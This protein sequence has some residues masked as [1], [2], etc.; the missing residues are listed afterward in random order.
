[1]A[2]KKT[3]W[4]YNR[5]GCEWN[6]WW[7]HHGGRRQDTV[8]LVAGLILHCH[9]SLEPTDLRP[10]SSITRR[11]RFIIDSLR[12]QHSR[13]YLPLL[14]RATHVCSLDDSTLC[15]NLAV[16]LL[17]PAPDRM[18]RIVLRIPMRLG[19]NLNSP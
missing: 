7:S 10:V 19:H 15:R 18:A 1:M 8:T 12:T 11:S 13:P 5:T 16:A 9:A 2:T 14:P 4:K 3:Q 17:T 6:R